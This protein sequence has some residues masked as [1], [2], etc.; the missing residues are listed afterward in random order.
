MSASSSYTSNYFKIYLWKFIGYF[1]GFASLAIVT[2]RITSSPAL[3][4]IFSF[5]MS[6][7]IFFQY[8]DLGFL[9]AAQKYASEYYGK[10]DRNGEIEVTGFSS[11]IFFIFMIPIS[12]GMLFIAYHPALIIKGINSGNELN[13]ASALLLVLFISSPILILQRIV[14]IIFSVRLEDYYTQRAG[15]V[16][17]VIRILSVFYFFGGGRYML[18]EY[19]ICYNALSLVALLYTASLARRKYRYDFI[20]LIRSFRFSKPLYKET[21]Q[22]AINSFFLSL[23][24]ILFYELDLLYIG[25]FLGKNEVAFYALALTLLKFFRDLYGTFYY[26]FVVRFN[27][28]VG[29]N[30]EDNLT[31]MYHTLLKVGIFVTTVPIASFMLLM[32]PLIYSWVGPTYN[33]TVMLAQIL[34]ASAIGGFITYPAG[35]LLTAK[36]ELRKLYL[37]AV[38]MPVIFFI[39]VAATQHWLGN[40][41]YAIFKTAAILSSAALLL[42][43]TLKYL[44]VTFVGF[45]SRYMKTLMLPLLVVVV[46]GFVIQNYFKPGKGVINLMIT[47]IGIGFLNILGFSIYYLQDRFFKDFFDGTVLKLLKKDKII[48]A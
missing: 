23:C 21:S 27:H 5:C 46:V 16:V 42:I 8:A 25:Y 39:G 38:I 41:A 19:F 12:F 11:F 18:L 10:G 24:W 33:S 47:G 43:F 34:I 31:T 9:N 7:N 20:K 2:P 48:K 45:I 1:S 32:R 30:E 3:F 4:G 35:A 40:R 28:F 36:V 13:L 14:Q 44:K 37:N 17:S 6:L 22:M 29:L 15:I 26:P